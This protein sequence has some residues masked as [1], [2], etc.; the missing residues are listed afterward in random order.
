MI[1]KKRH[2]SFINQLMVKGNKWKSEVILLK[3]AKKIQK[4][5]KN[6]INFVLKFAIINSSPYFHMK[7]LQR[8]KKK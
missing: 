2:D 5:Q 4:T 7:Q 8:K 3:T 6:Q 1:Y